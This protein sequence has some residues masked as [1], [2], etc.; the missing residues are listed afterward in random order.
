MRAPDFWNSPS[1]GAAALL[2]PL[3]WVYR[4]VRAGHVALASP[5]NAGAPVACVGNLVAG[6]AGK[7]PLALD[8]ARRITERGIA[9]HFL[10]RG[11]GGDGSIARRV[12]PERHDAARVGDEALLL[13]RVAPTWVG[14]DR[15]AS[16]EAAIADGA[17]VLLM[18]DG[19]QNPSIEKDVSVLA[20]D[21]AVGFGNHLLMPAGPLRE[22]IAAGLVRAHAAVILGEDE[23]GVAAEIERL[24][25]G[26]AVHQARLAPDEA[27]RGLKGR[28]VLGFAGIGRPAKFFA[29]LAE[30]GCEIAETRT[31]A[32]HHPYAPAE[33]D[34]LLERAD[35]LG[36]V[37]VT[38]A[39]D[40]ARLSDEARAGVTV[41]EVALEWRDESAAEG[42]VDD[43]LAARV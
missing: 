27:A 43:I 39:K 38:T 12:D 23:R 30:I 18:D 13:A 5:W 7:T 16:A 31:F 20:I 26:L 4:G 34:G 17:Q 22:P 3:G 14:A 19:F 33:I 29:T 15:R 40:A 28:R 10:T 37:A 9:V 35:A 2:A 41:V 32:D 24:A 21:G 11:Y 6:G 8:L 1:P 25:P 42:L 36:A